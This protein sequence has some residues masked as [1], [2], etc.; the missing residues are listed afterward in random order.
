MDHFKCNAWMARILE[1]QGSSE[2]RLLGQ[3]TACKV[4]ECS[5]P[6]RQHSTSSHF[7]LCLLHSGFPVLQD[8]PSA[9]DGVA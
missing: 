4:Q 6:A 1:R 7:S 9:I 2:P 5:G 3:N 8:V